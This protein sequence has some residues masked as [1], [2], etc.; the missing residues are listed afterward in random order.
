MQD[1]VN[2]SRAKHFLIEN[3]LILDLNEIY[4]WFR[5]HYLPYFFQP[6]PK[7]LVCS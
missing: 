6:Y 2:R 3:V 7:T 4:M 5:F 1:F